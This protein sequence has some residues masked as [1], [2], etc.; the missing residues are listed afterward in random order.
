VNVNVRMYIWSVEWDLTI[1]ISTRGIYS[2]DGGGGC[3]C[4]SLS[5]SSSPSIPL[6]SFVYK[7]GRIFV[8]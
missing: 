6:E 2:R 3:Y 5:S 8:E 7:T 1:T 4:R